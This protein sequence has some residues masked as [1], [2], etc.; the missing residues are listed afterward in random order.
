MPITLSESIRVLMPNGHVEEMKIETYLAGAVAAE[1]GAT[2]PPEALKAQTVASRTYVA[3]VQRHQEHG[4]DVC[5]TSHCQKWKRIDP[6]SAPEVFRAVSETWGMVLM[7][8]DQLI[9]AFFFEHCD[10]H[11]R[12][13][14]DMLMPALPYLRGVDCA[15]GFL[16]M[17]GHGVGM[18]KRGAIVMAR[19]GAT[20]DKILQHYYQG[21]AIVQPIRSEGEDSTV[22]VEELTPTPTRSRSRRKKEDPVVIKPTATVEQSDSA[23]QKRTRRRVAETSAPE[24]SI[25]VEP[26]P[27][28]ISR[29][30]SD[31]SVARKPVA[32]A[33]EPVAPRP[34]DSSVTRKAIASPSKPVAPRPTDSGVTRKIVAPPVSKPGSS[35]PVGASLGDSGVRFK[36]VVMP[37][38]PK[39]PIAVEPVEASSP[40][41]PS[42]EPVRSVIVPPVMPPVSIEPQEP[43]APRAPL[44]FVAPPVAPVVNEPTIPIEPVQEPPT[45]RVTLSF[46]TAPVASEPVAPIVEPTPDLRAPLNLPVVPVASEPPAPSV[47]PTL[48]L[49]A[50]LN[51]PVVPVISEPPASIAE[52]SPDLRASLDMPVVPVASEPPAPIAEPTP[53]LRASLDMPV[54]MPVP[55]E[56]QN[57]PSVPPPSPLPTP[58]PQVRESPSTIMPRIQLSQE[59]SSVIAKRVHVDQLPGERMIAGT[60]PRRGITLLIQDPQGNQKKIVSGTAPQYGDGGFEYRVEADGL[61]LVTIGG[62]TIEVQVQGETAFIH[63]ETTF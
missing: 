30:V 25:S 29:R 23:V 59:T 19:R 18:C 49:R 46:P 11:T 12:N 32:P 17:R 2:A 60:L 51:L 54:I 4:A 55:R 7:H 44:N 3:A 52:P 21:I 27:E 1:I 13:S 43:P 45:P 61:Y 9:N 39:P 20:F 62:R 35:E 22:V 37:P 48:E 26:P 56:F 38:T 24:P 10:G 5:T 41:P 63:A 57:A 50:P 15:C 58:A 14:E 34:T 28:K 42:I 16:A 53:D 47:E 36:T 31:S 8:D 40:M 6:V 33:N